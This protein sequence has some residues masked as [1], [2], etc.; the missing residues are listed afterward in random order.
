MNVRPK[1]GFRVSGRNGHGCLSLTMLTKRRFRSSNATLMG[2]DGVILITTRNPLLKTQGTFGPSSFDF[3]ELKENESVDLLLRAADEPSPWSQSSIQFAKEICR[4]LG[5]LPLALLHAGKTILSRLC[6]LDNY[7]SFFEKNW[8]RIR[9]LKGQSGAHAIQ[10]ANAAIYSSYELI[11]H[12]LVAK[13][14]QASKDALDLLKIFPFLH[15]QRIR[16]DIFLRAASNPCLEKW[17]QERQEKEELSVKHMKRMKPTWGQSFKC[18]RI[19]VLSYILKLGDLPV[20]P[21][22][23]SDSLSSDAI[24]ELRL[25]EALKE[26]N[27]MSLISANPNPEGDSYSMHAAVH[28][29]LRERP[30]MTVGDQAVWCHATATILTRAILIPPLGDK[31]EDEILRRDL[32]PHVRQIQQN[33]QKIR[34]RFL[35][36]QLSRRR[37]WPVLQPRLDRNRAVQLMKFSLVYTQCDQLRDAEKLQLEVADFAE[38]TLGIEHSAT[39]DVL[40]LLSSTY[41]RLTRG[42]EAAE[43][44]RRILE[45]CIR[46][47]GKDDLKT[48][49]IMD[50]YGSSL[51]WQGNIVEAR[52]TLSAACEGLKKVRGNDHVD[53]LRALGNLGRVLGRDFQFTK[54][55]RIHSRVLPGLRRQLGPSHLDTLIALHGL[56]MAYFDR[57]AHGFGHILDLDRAL[58]MVKEVFEQRKE[59]L[60]REHLYT[61]WAGLD[62]ARIHAVRGES[63]EALTTFL[64]GHE[65]ALRNYGEKHFAVLFGKLHYGRILML[66]DNYAQAE[67]ILVEVSESYEDKRKAHPDRLMALGSLIKCRN[68]LGRDAETTA[69]LLEELT[70]K[71]KMIFGEDHAWVKYLL[72]PQQLSQEPS[73]NVSTPKSRTESWD[74]NPSRTASWDTNLEII[75][76]AGGLT[77]AAMVAKHGHI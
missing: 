28:L 13:Q 76:P 67:S 3:A 29:W 39:M 46:V 74:I 1:V 44:Q 25:R 59:K 24:D 49:K 17:E 34:A 54:A 15:R 75:V 2:N 68:V 23:L 43:L 31:E 50:A 60:G 70:K 9:R 36:H 21:R 77:P 30:E 42:E 20:L 8:N 16:I 10:D 33:E 18:A 22:F 19:R 37:L 52:K 65:I 66:A 5:C 56:G 69:D 63:E 72:D 41:W 4:A 57:T 11:H 61:L 51:W 40:L 38:K 62:L 32:L 58:E 26:L 73:D 47:R 48:L 27:Q 6:T 12:G 45:A 55:I 14:T 7:L 35:E 64:A 71:V 53:T